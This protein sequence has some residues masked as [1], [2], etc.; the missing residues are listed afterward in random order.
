MRLDYNKQL[1]SWKGCCDF[2]T[3]LFYGRDGG[4]KCHH[5]PCNHSPLLPPCSLASKTQSLPTSKTFPL[6]PQYRGSSQAQSSSWASTAGLVL[7]VETGVMRTEWFWQSISSHSG[8]QSWQKQTQF[9]QGRGTARG[10]VAWNL[11]K[12]KLHIS[13]PPANSKS[14]ASMVEVSSSSPSVAMN[15]KYPFLK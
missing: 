2:K 5:L 1:C 12:G 6:T 11:L 14:T 3:L 13:L 10:R 9:A 15:L 8:G 7:R 4:R